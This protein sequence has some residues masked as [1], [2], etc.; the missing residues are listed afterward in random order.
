MDRIYGNRVDAQALSRLV[1]GF[2]QHTPRP[3]AKVEHIG[4]PLPCSLLIHRLVFPKSLT[5]M[6]SGFVECECS[7][8]PDVNQ[9]IRNG[10]ISEDVDCTC[11]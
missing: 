6:Y 9:A 8:S 3:T 4:Q 2:T 7:A 10:V 1:I 5:S 11:S